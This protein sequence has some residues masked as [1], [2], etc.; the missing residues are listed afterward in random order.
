VIFGR[1]AFGL[2]RDRSFAAAEIDMASP[3]SYWHW[4]YIVAGVGVSSLGLASFLLPAHF[5]D[6]GVT[7]VSMLFAKLSRLPLSVF[8][9][10]VNAPFVVLGYKH[11]GS[12]FAFRSSVAIVAQAICLAVVPFPAATTDKFLAAMFG[13]FFVGAGVGLAIRGGGVL[14]GT[15]ILAVLVS[16]RSFAT[17]GEVVLALNAIIFSAAAFSLGVEPALYSALT[18]FAGS[19]TIDYLLHGIEAYNGV[20]VVSGKHEAIREA[21]LRELNRGVTAFVAK[22]GFTASGQ[23]VLFCVVTRLEVTRLEGVVKTIDPSAFIVVL[24][25]HEATGGMV[26]KR[27]YH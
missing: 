2:P 25:V 22:G 26:K 7:G 17:V 13:G 27:A 9:V 23:E 21:I 1:G 20:L 10:A 14:D 6:G 15:E 19:K 5:I 11:V 8:L 24:P 18:Y 16:R 12:R 4:V 3:K